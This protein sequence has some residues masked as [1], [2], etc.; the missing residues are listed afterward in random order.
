MP[1]HFREQVRQSVERFSGEAVDPA[2][3]GRFAGATDT[4]AAD[5]ST[6]SAFSALRAAVEAA[7][8]GRGTGGNRLFY[9]AMPPASFSTPRTARRGR[10][11]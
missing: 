6:P 11:S 10:G 9:L 2:A 7:E 1:L 8:D 5:D 3:W 4:V